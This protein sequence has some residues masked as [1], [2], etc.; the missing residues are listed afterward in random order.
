MT[1]QN[2]NRRRRQQGMGMM[3]VDYDAQ[4]LGTPMSME[5]WP[6]QG[7]PEGQ[8]FST[9]YNPYYPNL[10]HTGSANPEMDPEYQA[11]LQGLFPNYYEQNFSGRS[12]LETSRQLRYN[13][14][15]PRGVDDQGNLLRDPGERIGQWSAGGPP[16]SVTEAGNPY[17][18]GGYQ[19]IFDPYSGAAMMQNRRERRRVGSDI[20]YQPQNP[21]VGF[22][23]RASGPG[24]GA[25]SALNQITGMR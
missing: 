9:G 10:P 22:V 12:P 7:D 24:F 3:P 16:T 17:Y 18:G 2:N 4:G 23:P 21:Q 8:Y 5:M 15:D 20:Q 6:Q 19:P 25:A 1:M 13:V 14:P 11:A